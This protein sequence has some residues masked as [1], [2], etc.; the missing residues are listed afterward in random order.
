MDKQQ[1]YEWIKI[2]L[3][4]VIAALL[5]VNTFQQEGGEDNTTDNSSA[6]PV[7][8][9]QITPTGDF[10]LPTNPAP[11]T[12]Q[13]PTTTMVFEKETADLGTIQLS[14]GATHTYSVK[15]SGSIPLTFQSVKGDPGLEIVSSPTSAIPPGESGEITVK[16]T[17]DAGEG[18]I[19]KV[20]HIGA[21]TQPGHVHLTL[22]ANVVK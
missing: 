13:P 19:S 1:Q 16:V 3:L 20:V 5:I 12:A 18:P 21:N 17:E 11:N 7:N 9:V 4:A 14:S 6:A 22:N 8:N 10:K 2:G 15:N